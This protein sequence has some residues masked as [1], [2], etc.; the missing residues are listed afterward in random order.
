[1]TRKKTAAPEVG[2]YAADAGS[3]PAIAPAAA[4]RNGLASEAGRLVDEM[5]ALSQSIMKMRAQVADIAGIT[6]FQF[7][8]VLR[9]AELKSAT[10]GSLAKSLSVSSQF[11]SS[12]VAKLEVL[13]IVERQP[14]E[15]DRR[16]SLV[17]LT[18]RGNLLVQKYSPARRAVDEKILQ[19]ATRA[20]VASLGEVVSVLRGNC[21]KALVRSKQAKL[22]R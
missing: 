19:G 6:A 4:A 16:G 22:S 18:R 14:K 2:S 9:I 5:L 8:A 1:M 12:E 17:R 10:I 21:R 7:G 15:T 20:Q 11:I 13:G 3:S